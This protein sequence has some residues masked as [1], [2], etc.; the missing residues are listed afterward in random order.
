MEAETCF[1]KIT[2]IGLWKCIHHKATKPEPSFVCP[3]RLRARAGGEEED[4]MGR[5][6]AQSVEMETW[7][8][9]GVMWE[10]RV[11]EG[12]VAQASLAWTSEVRTLH[13]LFNREQICKKIE[14]HQSLEWEGLVER[15]LTCGRFLI[16]SARSRQMGLW[17]SSLDGQRMECG[18]GKRLFL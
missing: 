14:A 18:A 16:L 10:E 17:Q 15:Q 6:E 13:C 12:R 7:V 9:G 3:C 8:R 5:R 1:S 2:E 4:G 11:R